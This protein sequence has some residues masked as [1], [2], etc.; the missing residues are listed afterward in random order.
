MGASMAPGQIA[1]TR[2]PY[3]ANSVASA[4][5]IATTAPLDAEYAVRL[6]LPRMALIEALLTIAPPPRRTKAGNAARQQ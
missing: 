2:T 5:V 4:L 1:L 3:E 6:M